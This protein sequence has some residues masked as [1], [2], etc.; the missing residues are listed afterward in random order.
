[1][2]P[3]SRRAGDRTTAGN[4]LRASVW[5]ARAS[6]IS[7]PSAPTSAATSFPSRRA[8]RSWRLSTNDVANTPARFVSNISVVDARIGYEWEA[9]KTKLTLFAKNI[10]DEQYLTSLA[11]D[12]KAPTGPDEATVADGRLVG[13]TVM[14]R[15]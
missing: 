11:A 8:F 3:R 13:V 6:T 2:A 4:C 10:L 12:N 1:M 14:Q 15:F 9:S 7:L 5:F